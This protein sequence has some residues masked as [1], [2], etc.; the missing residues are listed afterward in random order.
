[1]RLEIVD[2]LYAMVRLA[3]DAPVPSWAT[4][5]HDRFLSITRTDCELSIV[6]RES[7]VPPA[8]AAQRGWRCLRVAGNLPFDLVGVAAAIT[9]PLAA[10]GIALLLIATYETDYLF[11][12]QPGFASACDALEAA[13]HEVVARNA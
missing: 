8:I 6:C 11:V 4:D 7:A 1:M 12:A 10:A 5:A 3:P 2:G 9:A 13:G